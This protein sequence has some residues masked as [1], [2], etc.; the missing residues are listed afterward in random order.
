MGNT[1]K[2]YRWGGSSWSLA[3]QVYFW[4]GSAWQ[5]ASRIWRWDPTN[6]WIM[7]YSTP[8]PSC[9]TVSG[10]NSGLAV[11]GSVTSSAAAV[12]IGGGFSGSAS[13]AWA[14]VSGDAGI[15]CSN[16]TASNPTWTKS[17]VAAGTVSAVWSLTVTDTVTGA[18]ALI[19]VTIQLTW[20]NTE[21]TLSVSPINGGGNITVASGPVSGTVTTG[22]GGPAGGCTPSGGS[23]SY[24]SF[25]WSYFS[26]D[27]G[28]GINNS[29]LQNPTWSEFMSAAAG[30]SASTSATWQVI[31]TDSE[32]HTASTRVTI[33]LSV[34]SN[35]VPL[36]IGG[37]Q[38]GSGTVQIFTYPTTYCN[39]V[40]TGSGSPIPGLSVIQA[41]IVTGS[42]GTGSYN[43]SWSYVSGNTGMTIS[44]TTV[45]SPSF[46]EFLCTN[47][48]AGPNIVTAVYQCAVTDSG[49]NG[50]VTT[51]VT[52]QLGVYVNNE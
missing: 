33:S 9:G 36:A 20:T 38:N 5:A 32:G 48:E 42:G 22:S 25:A 11:S 39:T 27:S 24:T 21:T 29:A 23:G 26:G 10:S 43:Y 35:Q 30:S 8:S 47:A 6:N 41:A 52:I 13:Y 16:A 50:P 51:N 3:N 14:Y 28:I 1:T 31:V 45:S 49:G 15:L 19:D 40:V 17:S 44:S 4:N 46:S 7:C 12:S 37:T 2:M 18:T 34:V